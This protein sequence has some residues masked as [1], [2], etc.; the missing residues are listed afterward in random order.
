MPQV[1]LSF[2]SQNS[3]IILSHEILIENVQYGH[4]VGR[5]CGEQFTWE[6]SGYK[7]TEVG[8]AKLQGTWTLSYNPK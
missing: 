3:T 6:S 2:I 4:F 7:A 5:G 8:K 1:A